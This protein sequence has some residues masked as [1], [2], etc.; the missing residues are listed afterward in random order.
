MASFL[1]KIVPFGTGVELNG[2][3]AQ[4]LGP[5]LDPIL[6]GSILLEAASRFQLHLLPSPI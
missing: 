5:F 2:L 6:K 4:L 1:E 3:L